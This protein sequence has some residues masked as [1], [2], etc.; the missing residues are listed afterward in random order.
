MIDS[1]ELADLYRDRIVRQPGILA[2]KPVV[3]GT[4]ISVDLVVGCFAGGMSDVE[5]LAEFPQVTRDDLRAC[6]AYAADALRG[7]V[8]I[9]SAA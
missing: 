8:P 4:R 3:A 6:L 1:M 2:G 5:I 9:G 7:Q